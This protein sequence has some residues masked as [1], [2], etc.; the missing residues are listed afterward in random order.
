MLIDFWATWCGPCKVVLPGL[1]RLYQE[2]H[3]KGLEV[4][5][6]SNDSSFPDLR[7]FMAANKD[8]AWPQSFN[9]GPK[10]W[11]TLSAKMDVAL[12]PTTF[13]IDRDGILRDIETGFLKEDLVKKLLAQPAK[14][15]A[16]T[17]ATGQTAARGESRSIRRGGKSRDR[18]RPRRATFC[19]GSEGKRALVPG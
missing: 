15:D 19:V 3:A 6:I 16:S 4:L 8:M 7:N 11:N 2:N 17:S 14:A 18:P 9:P 13:I 1:I 10:G 5:G 12:I